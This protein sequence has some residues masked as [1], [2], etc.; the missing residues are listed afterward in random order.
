[1]SYD[2]DLDNIKVETDEQRRDNIVAIFDSL[3]KVQEILS[4]IDKRLKAGGL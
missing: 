4:D 2:V 1:M 3:S